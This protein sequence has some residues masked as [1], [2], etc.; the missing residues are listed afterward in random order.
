MLHREGLLSSDL[1]LPLDCFFFFWAYCCNWIYSVVWT[2]Y[3]IWTLHHRTG[4]LLSIEFFLPFDC[5]SCHSVFAVV[6]SLVVIIY[7][8]NLGVIRIGS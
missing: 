4:C 3:F 1:V 5:F 6:V 2:V 8:I 7:N